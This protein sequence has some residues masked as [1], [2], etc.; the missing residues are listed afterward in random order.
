MG[1]NTEAE[2]EAV[3]TV[4]LHTSKPFKM[5]KV[6]DQLVELRSDALDYHDKIEVSGRKRLYSLIAGVYEIYHAAKIEDKIALLQD[7]VVE[8]LRELPDPKDPKVKYEPS[9][10][11]DISSLL[12][13]FVFAADDK[14][15]SIWA[16]ALRV[17][18]KGGVAPSQ[19]ID[20]VEEQTGG[21]GGF[22]EKKEPKTP[23]ITVD[24][25]VEVVRKSKNVTEIEEFTT[26]RYIDLIYARQWCNEFEN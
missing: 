10:N 5:A 3:M 21:I 24:T 9:K 16:K 11:A 22:S 12:I 20:S 4:S 2:K 25:A 14:Q 13:R 8:K 23:K 1:A 26:S 19:F 7:K 15:I 17:N 18:Y 6:M